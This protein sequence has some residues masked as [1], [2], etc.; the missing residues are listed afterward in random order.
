MTDPVWNAAILRDAM[1]ELQKEVHDLHWELAA[2]R[3]RMQ[4]EIR[5]LRR[6]LLLPF[7]DWPAAIDQ[8]DLTA[9]IHSGYSCLINSKQNPN[10]ILTQRSRSSPFSLFLLLISLSVSIKL[11]PTMTGD[12]SS[13]PVKLKTSA[14]P[15][16]KIV[17]R[18]GQPPITAPKDNINPSEPNPPKPTIF[19]RYRH[20]HRKNQSIRRSA[21][22][23]AALSPCIAKPATAANTH[24]PSSP[25]I[26]RLQPEEPFCCRHFT[27][28]Q[29]L[30]CHILLT[31]SDGR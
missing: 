18:I 12:S 30:L 29:P 5:R 27:T 28:M 23:K 7:E 8:I 15:F 26:S 3:V 25:M 9:E 4:R 6:A 11:R 14:A 24:L 17:Q 31:G 10:V 21:A 22:P 13:A 2:V 16:G 20:Q 19:C 1:R